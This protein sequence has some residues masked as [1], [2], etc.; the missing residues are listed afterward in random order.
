MSDEDPIPPPGDAVSDVRHPTPSA[1]ALQPRALPPRRVDPRAG[2]PWGLWATVGWMFALLVVWHGLRA[3][4]AFITGGVLAHMAAASTAESSESLFSHNFGLITSLWGLALAPPMLAVIALLSAVR[5]DLSIR[6]YLA[7][8]PP[9]PKQAA[10]WML[11]MVAVTGA[12][13][14][15]LNV[16]GFEPAVNYGRLIY[17]TAPLVWLLLGVCVAAPVLEEMWMRGFLYGG[18]A[19][20]SVG[21]L[22]AI[23]LTTVLFTLMHTHYE[24]PFL[25]TVLALGLYL[26]IVRWRTGSTVLAILCHATA[27][28]Y[29]VASAAVEVHLFA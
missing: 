20:S 27:N 23:L 19:A 22:G 6:D 26:G 4:L 21:P 9:S 1:Q 5:R 2:R 24:W 13:Q 8:V 10:G 16:S 12:G 3:V 25:L 29:Y 18:L 17:E 7:I 11:G 14:L 15:A 28:L